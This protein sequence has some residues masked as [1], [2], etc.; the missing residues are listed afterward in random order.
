[1]VPPRTPSFAGAPRLA[2][3]WLPPGTAR[4]RPQIAVPPD[5]AKENLNES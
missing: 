3:A 4:L 1:M 2:A 5:V